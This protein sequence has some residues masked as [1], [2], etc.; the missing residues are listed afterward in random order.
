MCVCVCERE[1]E[2]HCSGPALFVIYIYFVHDHNSNFLR[3]QMM[4]ILDFGFLNGKSIYTEH[5]SASFFSCL[6]DKLKN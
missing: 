4:N 2:S 1:R 6:L 3:L 5:F